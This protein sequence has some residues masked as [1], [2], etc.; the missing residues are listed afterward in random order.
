MHL[1]IL[2]IYSLPRRCVSSLDYI[3]SNGTMITEKELEKILKVVVAFFKVPSQYLPGWNEEIYKKEVSH[4][5]QSICWE[6][7]WVRLEYN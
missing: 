1:L 7:N 3:V 4:A 2:F 5:S 6:L